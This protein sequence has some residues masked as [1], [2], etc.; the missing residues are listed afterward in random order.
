MGFDIFLVDFVRKIISRIT[1]LL[2]IIGCA[3]KEYCVYK[4]LVLNRKE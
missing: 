1:L 3:A 2:V 4:G